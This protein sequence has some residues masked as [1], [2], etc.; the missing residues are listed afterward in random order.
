MGQPH[1]KQI[2]SSQST[3]DGSAL[4]IPS[5]AARGGGLIVG[6]DSYFLLTLPTWTKWTRENENRQKAN[7]CGLAGLSYLVKICQNVNARSVG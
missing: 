5:L 1:P 7:V 6:H 2:E 3:G 4:F